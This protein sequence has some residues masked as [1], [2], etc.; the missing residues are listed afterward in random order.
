MTADNI[1]TARFGAPDSIQA[2]QRERDPES[3]GGQLRLS[4]TDA[5]RVIRATV[6]ERARTLGL[7]SDFV[8]HEICRRRTP[9]SVL[10]FLYQLEGSSAGAPSCRARFQL[11]QARR[12]LAGLEEFLA[13]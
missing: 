6:E 10:A 7:Q 4:S 2:R 1:P 13:L 12:L 11:H 9:A 3:A 8:T 5:M